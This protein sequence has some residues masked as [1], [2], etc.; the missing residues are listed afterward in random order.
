MTTTTCSA[1][2][3]VTPGRSAHSPE[4]DV[5]DKQKRESYASKRVSIDSR[6]PAWNLGNILYVDSDC[7]LR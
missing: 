3:D 4:Q 5:G 2:R 1:K 7:S 6:D